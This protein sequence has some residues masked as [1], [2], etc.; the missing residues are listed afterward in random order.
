MIIIFLTKT[1][2]SYAISSAKEKKC[3]KTR[4]NLFNFAALFFTK[5]VK[6]TAERAKVLSTYKLKLNT[7][8]HYQIVKKVVKEIFC[9]S[10]PFCFLCHITQFGK[11]CINLNELLELLRIFF[12]RW[13]LIISLWGNLYLAVCIL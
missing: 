2:T 10:I 6:W 7:L 3:M 12:L 8:I 13:I 4:Q 11:E 9:P 5:C 1:L